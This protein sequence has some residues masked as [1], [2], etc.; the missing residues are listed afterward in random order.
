[1]AFKVVLLGLSHKTA[2]VELRER[3][4]LEEP[5]V[6]ALLGGF[7][8]QP[9]LR[10]LAYIGTCNRVELLGVAAA[11]ADA[12]TAL[13]QLLCEASG[14][15]AD[16]FAP[17]LYYLE[18]GDAV[19]HVFL[20]ASS[21]DSMVVGETEVLGQLKSAYRL[22][23]QNAS[24]G[25]VLHALF[26]RAFRV[27]KEL[28]TLGALGWGRVSVASVAV[29]FAGH[30][31][32]GFRDKAALLVGAGEMARRILEHLRERGLG[33][34]LVLNRSPERAEALA[35]EF[36]A[37]GTAATVQAYGLE[38]LEEVLPRA[39]IV[40]V[41]T[42]AAEP[43]VS[44]R[45]LAAALR[46][47]RGR[48]IFVVDISVPRNVEPA[49]GELTGVYLYDIDDLRS[50]AEANRARRE[51][52][53]SRLMERVETEAEQFMNRLKARRVGPLVTA[54]RRQAHRQAEQELEELLGRVRLSGV[55]EERLRE[56]VRRLV[57]RLLHQPTQALKTLSQQDDGFLYVD[58]L[59]RLFDLPETE[60]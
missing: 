58:A 48:P 25:P 8:R 53:V 16:A 4:A 52:Q 10:E 44:R 34:V 30:I 7:R 22:A 2:P 17:C 33:E 11:D 15:P 27:A 38:A 49:A 57:N 29:E 37:E 26:Q 18:E 12:R 45:A 51:A 43:V 24:L 47:R 42:G 1:M 20:V 31:F 50:V 13:T 21:L 39:D 32:A 40:L 5:A 36:T 3:L 56:L 19:A 14:A 28:H 59:R 41:S 55:Q 46:R 23:Q 35:R 60:D 9:G 54:L 6:E